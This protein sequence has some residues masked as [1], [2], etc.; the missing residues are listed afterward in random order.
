[1][2][3]LSGERACKLEAVAVKADACNGGSG[4]CVCLVNLIKQQVQK[5]GHMALMCPVRGWQ[6]DNDSNMKKFAYICIGPQRALGPCHVLHFI[7]R[8]LNKIWMNGFYFDAAEK[9]KE[10]S[11][12]TQE[13]MWTAG[14]AYEAPPEKQPPS[15]T[16]ADASK[17][18]EAD[19]E[20]G[21]G[22]K[23]TVLWCF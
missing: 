14:K 11:A 22:G 21:R 17:W 23:C 5:S 7:S 16:A 3:K 15:W 4:E 6:P 10:I 12:L 9:Y 1:M 13:A 19:S 18:K 2:E 20:E 8:K